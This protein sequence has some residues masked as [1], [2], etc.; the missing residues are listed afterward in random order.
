VTAT[1]SFGIPLTLDPGAGGQRVTDVEIVVPVYNE[2]T[3]LEPSIRR[4]HQY[5][6]AR[7]PLSWLVTIAPL[8]VRVVNLPW[9]RIRGTP[10]CTLE[11][12]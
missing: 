11:T 7:F 12:A 3:D 1:A 6:S 4:L 5:L 2:E 8:G 10:L 9:N